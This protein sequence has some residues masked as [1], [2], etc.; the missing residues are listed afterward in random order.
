MGVKCIDCVVKGG[1][2][3]VPCTCAVLTHHDCPP[4]GETER[5]SVVPA[6]ELHSGMSMAM[7]QEALAQ[8]QICTVWLSVVLLS[9]WGCWADLV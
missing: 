1:L 2:W 7:H 9:Y 6:V 8:P 3:L 4:Y 5:Q